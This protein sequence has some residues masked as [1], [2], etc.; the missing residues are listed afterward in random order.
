MAL[1]INERKYWKLAL[2]RPPLDV[3][4]DALPSSELV[5]CLQSKLRKMYGNTGC[6]T[7]PS[8]ESAVWSQIGQM[9]RQLQE[10]RSIIS[11]FIERPNGRAKAIPQSAT[12]RQLGEYTN[13]AGPGEKGAVAQYDCLHHKLTKTTLCSA[14][15]R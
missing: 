8:E 6:S 9:V 4:F 2:A 11:R 14:G 15:S 3:D 13:N 5:I 12:S 10:A 7:D 1:T